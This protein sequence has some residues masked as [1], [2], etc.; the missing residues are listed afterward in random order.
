MPWNDN[1]GST[2]PA[3]KLASSNERVIRSL[4]GP[5]SGKS[6]AIKRR[7]QRLI[8]NGV[9]PEKI[10]AITFT[11]TS[12][13]DLRK[14]ISSIE[15][16]GVENVQSRTVHSH[17]M[18][19]LMKRE[20]QEIIERNPRI[21][22]DHELAPALRDI[23]IPIDAGIREKKRLVDSFI[24]GWATLQSEVPGY[25]RNHDEETFEIQFVDWLKQHQALLVG[26]V[27]YLALNFLR[28]NPAS[29]EIGKFDA[30][31][32]DEYQD[33]NKAEQEFIHAF[34]GNASIVI[35][36]DDDQSIYSFKF[37]HPEGIKTI[38]QMYGEY[39]DVPFEVIRRC[40]QLV[41]KLASSL[42]SR[43]NNRSLGVLV[44]Y[45]RN[46]EG[47]VEIVQWGD[48][49]K[50]IDGLVKIIKN[51]IDTERVKPKD[52]LVLSPRRKIGYKLRDKLLVNHINVKS[53]FR[54]SAITNDKVK[55]AYSLLFLIAFPDDKV[56]IRFLL[57][58]TA[59]DFRK[60]QYKVLTKYATDN[61]YTIREALNK[62]LSENIQVRGIT[63]IINE[64]RTILS[65]I[66]SIKSRLIEDAKNLFTGF[67]DTTDDE[68]E[69]YELNSI[70][71]KALENHPRP[72]NLTTEMINDWFP[73][74][75][76][77]IT[78]GIAMPDSPE[79]I[80]HVRI[81]SLHAAKG[82]SAK[83]VIL[84][85]MVE[86]LMPSLNNDLSDEDKQKA[87][88]EQRR[89]F[90]VAITRCKSGETGYP[91]RLLISSFIWM[92]STDAS[93]MR[94]PAGYSANTQMSTTR[95]VSELGRLSPRPI[96]GDIL[97]CTN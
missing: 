60:N 53:Y 97:L 18:S 84:T 45:E 47:I 76:K 41:T 94:I 4:A 82:L 55:R 81:M 69:F 37:A 72:E 31:L 40:P 90:Y 3:Y 33:L 79:N 39:S 96:T 11:R 42:I 77:D 25:P 12:A 43:N 32:V 58:M 30:I 28:N 70:Y 51:E 24:A 17:A 59:P 1:L 78:E 9:L 65:E 35:V 6:F 56:S 83:F 26:E 74:I 10:L 36:G 2:D 91:G 86:G 49:R 80:D 5:G 13:A 57:G 50:E 8:E 46:Q 27:I 89:L 15:A 19:I 29:P 22:L 73:D 71:L 52:I 93:S 23:E 67:Y 64:Y 63:T 75:M 85:S 62:L 21:I 88:E 48:D 61:N 95:F 44:P 7:I 68:S 38:D 92:R 54:E 66:N 20:V 14:E 16:P 34:R 87:L